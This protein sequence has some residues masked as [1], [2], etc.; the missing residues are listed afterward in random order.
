MT[1][2][3]K[4]EARQ[5]PVKGASSAALED[6]TPS[7]ILSSPLRSFE[8][9]F[10]FLGYGI[11][12]LVLVAALLELASWAILSV[13]IW[14]VHPSVEQATR[15][16]QKTSPVYEGVGWAKEFWEEEFLRNQV[17]KVYV[18]FRLWSVTNWHGKYINNDAG[19]RGVWR[20]TL[21]P[22]NCDPR[23]SLDVWTFGGSTMYGYGVPD[24]ATIPS[25]LSRELNA[26]SQNCV[27]VSN[28]G[29]EGYVNDQELITLEEQL[30]AG[31]HPDI[32]VF[33][34]GVNDS[35]LTWNPSGPPPAHFLFGTIKSRVEG[36]VSG[37][38]D[39]L[40]TSYTVRLARKIL[41]KIRPRQ[42]FASLISRSQPNVPLVLDNYE[43]NLR[44][45]RALSNAYQ[46]KLY[47][48]W[49][50]ILLYG[51]KPLVPF[52][53][54]MAE[55]DAS[56]MSAATAWF[57][58]MRAVYQEAEHRAAIDGNFIFLGNMFDS[59]KDPIYVDEVHLGP[60]GNELAAKAIA[61]YV[62]AI[63]NKR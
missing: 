32:V 15:M 14:S 29:V 54:H 22:S 56:G 7:R 12:C 40:Q 16:I 24:W 62:R 61:G 11:V 38:L 36:S 55:V 25:Y 47:C 1:D 39:F 2:L 18:P 30:K 27:V 4:G 63:P 49:Q 44:I 10:A 3:R 5:Q 20:R 41:S 23:R 48:F 53:Q 43:A 37:R 52:E 51:Q 26:S 34:D 31:A 8:R 46:F 59:T 58:V 50:P 35:A 60:E 28:F 33:Y 21:N 57:P 17:L 45:A 19:P 6:P 13:R 9:Y 42:S